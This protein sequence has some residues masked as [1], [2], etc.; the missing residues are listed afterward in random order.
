MR[1]TLSAC[2]SLAV[3]LVFGVHP[4]PVRGTSPKISV[5]ADSVCDDLI[6]NREAD[7]AVRLT[8]RLPIL[9]RLSPVG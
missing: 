9:I 2:V 1:V 6:T 3:V 7:L 8:V 4:S 5:F